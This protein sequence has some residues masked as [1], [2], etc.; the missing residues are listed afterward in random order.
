MK[1]YIYKPKYLMQLNKKIKENTSKKTILQK[2]RNLF[3]FSF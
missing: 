3:S 2:I 1:N